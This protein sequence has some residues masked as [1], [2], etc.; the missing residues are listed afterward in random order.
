M[1]F[2]KM[3]AVNISGPTYSSRTLSNRKRHGVD[4]PSFWDWVGLCDCLDE[5]HVGEVILPTSEGYVIKAGL[6]F[7]ALSGNT[8]GE[9]YGCVQNS[10][11]LKLG[12][13]KT[14]QR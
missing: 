14:T 10:G 5:Q 12:A 1:Y 3:A 6:S 4:F 9:L 2:L 11:F 7:R 13:R 8:S